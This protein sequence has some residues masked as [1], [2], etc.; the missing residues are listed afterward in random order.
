VAY[1]LPV[2]KSS[3]ELYDLEANYLKWAYSGEKTLGEAS[4]ELKAEADAILSKMN[5]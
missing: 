1:P 4:K 2:C 5:K 3:A